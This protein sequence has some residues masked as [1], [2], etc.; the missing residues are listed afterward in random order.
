MAVSLE[1]FHWPE[2]THS[3]HEVAWPVVIVRS[4]VHSA[5]NAAPKHDH[6]TALAA[7]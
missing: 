5:A 3:T 6:F 4:S 7:L 1:L 2:S